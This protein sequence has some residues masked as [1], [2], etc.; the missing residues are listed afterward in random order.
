M[1]LLNIHHDIIITVASVS[2]PLGFFA[3]MWFATLLPKFFSQLWDPTYHD[4]DN[5]QHHIHT[6]AY[7]LFKQCLNDQNNLIQV[8]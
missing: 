7:E 5:L 4:F 2:N 1:A 3:F 6:T 8:A